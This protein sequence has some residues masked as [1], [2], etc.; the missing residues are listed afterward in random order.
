MI[1]LEITVDYM[2]SLS[3]RIYPV[4]VAVVILAGI[5]IIVAAGF[6]ASLPI[7][8]ALG[9][10]GVGLIFLGIIVIRVIHEEKQS[11]EKLDVLLTGL[12][13]LREEMKQDEKQ[14]KSGIAIADIISSSL[15]FYADYKEK[16]HP[17][18]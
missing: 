15:K 2:K 10:G 13:E 6:A 16:E 12:D 8:I 14:G 9:L 17:E 4:A 11:Q 7:Q 5:G 18:E 1:T 3:I